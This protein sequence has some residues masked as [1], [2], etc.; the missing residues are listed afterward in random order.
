MT[1]LHALKVISECAD[2]LIK[3]DGNLNARQH[4]ELCRTIEHARK[5]IDLGAM[6]SREI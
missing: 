3:H 6:A 5:A 2:E 4:R 1:Y